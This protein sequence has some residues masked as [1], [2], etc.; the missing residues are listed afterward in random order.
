MPSYE[1]AVYN[2]AVREKTAI[3]ERHRFL[4]DDWADIHYI[5]IS[6]PSIDV[7]RSRAEANYSAQQGYVIVSIEEQAD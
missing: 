7:A 3:G 4:S 6:A 2:Q 5:E 1:I